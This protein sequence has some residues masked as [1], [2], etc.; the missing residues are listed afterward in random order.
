MVNHREFAYLLMQ[1]EEVNAV[2]WKHKHILSRR[3]A[4]H[5]T[6]PYYL[7]T[8]G[9]DPAVEDKTQE[10]KDYNLAR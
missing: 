4:K 2:L 6:A 10:T 1:R 8:Y 5:I 7:G 3:I 9:V